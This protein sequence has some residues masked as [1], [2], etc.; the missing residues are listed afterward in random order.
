[1]DHAR[2]DVLARSALA[3]NE[4]WYVSGGN[5]VHARPQGL[6]SIRMTENDGLG[7]NLADGLH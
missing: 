5:F 6:H 2:D 3:L 4:N 7:R 1:M